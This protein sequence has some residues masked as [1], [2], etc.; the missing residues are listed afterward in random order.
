MRVQ[1]HE[2]QNQIHELR[3]QIHEF[4]NHPVYEG[5][6]GFFSKYGII[7][8]HRVHLRFYLIKIKSVLAELVRKNN[9][10]YYKKA[11]FM[12][13]EID[14]VGEKQPFLTNTPFLNKG[15]VKFLQIKQDTV[16]QKCDQTHE[17]RV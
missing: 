4:K 9:F 2:L 12:T 3:V 5:C 11:N 17:K 13:T 16:R 7:L 6:T 8:K 15:K 14:I 10:K 1:I